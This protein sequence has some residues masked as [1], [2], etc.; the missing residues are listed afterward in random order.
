LLAAQGWLELGNHIEANTELEQVS[1]EL[2]VYPDV[3][4]LRWR[5]Y[6]KAQEWP[7]CLDIAEALIKLA[8]NRPEGWVDRSFTLHVLRRTQEAFDQLLPVADRFSEVWTIPYNLACYCAQL[9]RLEECKEWFKKAMAVNEHTVKSA[10]VDDPDLQPVW[11][12]M[13]GTYWRCTDDA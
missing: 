5:I 11:D 3:L 13:S 10:A 6:C 7:S 4:E 8:P 12:S 2:R 9:G 1:P